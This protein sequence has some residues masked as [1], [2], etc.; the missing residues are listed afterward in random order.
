MIMGDVM[1][2]EEISINVVLSLVA[3]T[4]TTFYM[5][6]MTLAIKENN[7]SKQNE[8]NKSEMLFEKDSLS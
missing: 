4:A 2:S 8:K 5:H 6:N 7:S 1:R 3:V